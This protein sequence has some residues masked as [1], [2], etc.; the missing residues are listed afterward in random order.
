MWIFGN[1]K[2]MSPVTL[3]PSLSW[4]LLSVVRQE[5]LNFCCVLCASWSGTDNL[6]HFAC[7]GSL[8]PVWGWNQAAQDAEWNHKCRH[9]PCSLRKC[10]STAAHHEDA[11]VAQCCHLHQRRKQKCL[12]WAKR[13]KVGSYIVCVFACVCVCMCVSNILHLALLQFVLSPNLSV[14]P[15]T[16]HSYYPDW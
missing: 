9:N 11:R 4:T 8:S 13:C 1:S 14:S 2:Q 15:W 6:V 16:K 10:L 12:L 5:W 3:F 7:R